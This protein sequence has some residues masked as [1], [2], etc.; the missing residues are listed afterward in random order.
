M[1]NMRKTPL[2]LAAAF[3]ITWF[4]SMLHNSFIG[5]AWPLLS[6][7]ALLAIMDASN[8]PQWT[9]MPR[10]FVVKAVYEHP[11]DGWDQKFTVCIKAHSLAQAKRRF[12]AQE[13][14]EG[15]DTRSIKIR[16]IS[17]I[18]PVTLGKLRHNAQLS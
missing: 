6:G 8:T 15:N 7:V 9:W 13:Q 17:Q 10:K 12:W 4:V 18:K 5:A 3:I 11:F 16:D 2:L 1:R 14:A